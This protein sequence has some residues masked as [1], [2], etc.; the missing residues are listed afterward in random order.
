MNEVIQEGT[1]LLWDE[2]EAN[3]NPEL[4]SKLA[5][6]LLALSRHG[7]QVILSTHEDH[8]LDYYSIRDAKIEAYDKRLEV[9]SEWED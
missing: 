8:L 4:M 3:L 9:E 6:W 2:P 5:G 1:V 7:I